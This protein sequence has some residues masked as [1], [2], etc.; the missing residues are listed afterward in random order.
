MSKSRS[1]ARQIQTRQPQARQPDK[2]VSVP[3]PL[4]AS[5]PVAKVPAAVVV[6]VDVPAAPA[7]VKPVPP[8]WFNEQGYL[9]LNPDVAAA[10]QK[11]LFLSPY[12]HYQKVGRKEGRLLADI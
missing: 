3:A 7:P 2:P 5:I 6:S 9:N 12:D 10:I 8:F 11:G 4:S 1:Q